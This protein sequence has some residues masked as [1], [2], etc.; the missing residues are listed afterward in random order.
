M[1]TEGMDCIV[2]LKAV[3]VERKLPGRVSEP[4]F[5]GKYITF[6]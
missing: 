4:F 1:N 5:S 2:K 6:N 3:I